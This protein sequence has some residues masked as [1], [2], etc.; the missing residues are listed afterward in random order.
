MGFCYIARARHTSW[1]R[2]RGGEFGAGGLQP[3]HPSP[4][5]NHPSS[6]SHSGNINKIP[7]G[8][9]ECL[10]QPHTSAMPCGSWSRQ[11]GKGDLG[12]RAIRKGAE[13][14]HPTPSP[15]SQALHR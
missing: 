4:S 1:G 3:D 5:S 6:F 2:I 13:R 8:F 14:N 9:T 15:E 11:G 10:P 7:S 12:G